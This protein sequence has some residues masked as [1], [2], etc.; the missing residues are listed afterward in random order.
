MPIAILDSLRASG[1]V[2]AFDQRGTGTSDPQGVACEGGMMLA[3][4]EIVAP[5]ARLSALAVQLRA[6]LERRRPEAWTS[7]G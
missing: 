3:R 5:A 1:D 4:A 7:R 6:C 2:I